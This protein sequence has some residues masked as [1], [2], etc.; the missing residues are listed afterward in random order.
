[1]CL[2]GH[3][4]GFLSVI[5]LTINCILFRLGKERMGL[6]IDKVCI[7]FINMNIDVACFKIVCIF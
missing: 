3:G 1:M 2:S 6:I 7:I 4:R 5:K